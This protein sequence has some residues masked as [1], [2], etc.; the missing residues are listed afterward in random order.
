MAILGFWAACYFWAQEPPKPAEP[1]E[2]DESLAPKEY[3]FN[4]LQA[5]QELKVG[6]FYFK[7]G[8]YRAAAARFEEATRWNPGYA[9]AY[10]RLGEARE[11]MKDAAGARKA[12]EK[13]LELEPH[14]KRA[15]E[16]RKKLGFQEGKS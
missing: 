10:L 2:E 1:P 14:G 11:R 8:N 9:E 6:N 15:A 4:P 13:Y 5:E 16:I 7:K 3:A 12:F